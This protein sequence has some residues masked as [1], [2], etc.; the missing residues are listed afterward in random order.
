MLFSAIILSALAIVC[1]A[2]WPKACVFQLC[3]SADTYCSSKHGCYVCGA[4]STCHSDTL[5]CA[6]ADPNKFC[7]TYLCSVNDAV[8]WNNAHSC[9]YSQF[10]RSNESQPTSYGICSSISKCTLNATFQAAPPT[11]SSDRVCHPVTVCTPRQYISRPPTL[12]TDRTCS[13]PKLCD[14]SIEYMTQNFTSTSDRVCT[15]YEQ[16]IVDAMSVSMAYG[17]SDDPNSALN[18]LQLAKDLMTEYVANA[19]SPQVQP[20]WDA[21][22]QLIVNIQSGFDMTGHSMHTVIT[23]QVWNAPSGPKDQLQNF[24]LLVQQYE[25]ILQSLN[26][27]IVLS[28]ELVAAVNAIDSHID[29][30]ISDVDAQLHTIEGALSHILSTQQSILQQVRQNGQTLQEIKT[31]QKK[32]GFFSMLTTG[33]SLGIQAIQK[34]AKNSPEEIEAVEECVDS[35]LDVISTSTEV[36][37]GVGEVAE[38]IPLRHRR[39]FIAAV[40]LSLNGSDF[41][42]L[43]ELRYFSK[44]ID[45]FM[46]KFEAPS[47]GWDADGNGIVSTSEAQAFVQDVGMDA[48]VAA[49]VLNESSSEPQWPTLLKFNVGDINVGAYARS[50]LIS[51]TQ[52]LFAKN[53]YLMT[54]WT[55]MSISAMPFLYL[56]DSP[57]ENA[58]FCYGVSK[59]AFI[60]ARIQC[61]EAFPNRCE[62]ETGFG[63]WD[64]S[65]GGILCSPTQKNTALTITAQSKT[66][67]HGFYSTYNAS[68]KATLAAAQWVASTSGDNSSTNVSSDMSAKDTFKSYAQDLEDVMVLSNNI[69]SFA[70]GDIVLGHTQ[71][72]PYNLSRPDLAKKYE[73]LFSKLVDGDQISNSS[74]QYSQGARL[75]LNSLG[76]AQQQAMFYQL[77]EARRLMEQYLQNVSG[78]APECVLSSA[79]PC[80]GSDLQQAVSYISASKNRVLDGC[81]DVLHTITQSISYDVLDPALVD[82]YT[83]FGLVT[84]SQ[85][86]STAI[87]QLDTLWQLSQDNL[88]GSGNTE[89]VMY[90]FRRDSHE[91]D[92][93]AFEQTGVLSITVPW[94]TNPRQRRAK[95]L[96]PDIGVY[97]TGAPDGDYDTAIVKGNYSIFFP[98]SETSGDAVE[99]SEYLH[100]HTKRSMRQMDATEDG[101]EELFSSS[102][103]QF[104]A[105]F[106][107]RRSGDTC[108]AY[109]GGC[110]S[111]SCHPDDYLLVSPYGNWMIQARASKDGNTLPSGQFAS[112]DVIRLVFQV[113]YYD[114]GS[115]TN[116]LF[117][118]N[119]CAQGSCLVTSTDMSNCA[120]PP[121]PQGSTG[122][123][124]SIG[125]IAGASGG[126]FFGVVG[127]AFLVRKVI[128]HRRERSGPKYEFVQESSCE[129][130]Q[131]SDTVSIQ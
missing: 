65:S 77:Y 28:A 114:S 61:K 92:F 89:F 32:N 110:T 86:L 7:A 17:Y 125:M 82:R 39:N 14:T 91:L 126:G 98:L 54:L 33:L 127:A 52:P 43:L 78:S 102:S 23:T 74:A 40:D 53:T 59:A 58:T 120:P 104:I 38:A 10:F 75:Y 9:N 35:P 84:S 105:N 103:A 50:R 71:T 81:M 49:A 27:E 129:S 57:P 5:P 6:S 66:M 31:Q 94:P 44:F 56:A 79:V 115:G 47:N 2:E 118:N 99:K 113:W 3:C 34:F 51:N 15:K 16:G 128:K 122:H 95:L 25:S 119:T 18:A 8:N 45:N 21:L 109:S 60:D 107:Y 130:D 96:S 1:S 42:N 112:V 117:F 93:E 121:S 11:E 69:R 83:T 22:N 30:R 100:R 4:S 29:E 124:V 106:G 73:T 72:Q 88:G 76:A 116:N 90:N 70:K 64:N 36:L 123:K 67:L 13:M 41:Q 37:A 24:L 131:E 101:W 62:M 111:G 55:Y 12:T 108:S 19:T 48:S 87:D 63:L 68:S 97:F 26:S 46:E 20:L 80:Y 85:E